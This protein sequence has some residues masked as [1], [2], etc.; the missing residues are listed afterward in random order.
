MTQTLFEQIE[1]ILSELIKIMLPEEY[2]SFIE[3]ETLLTIYD[4]VAGLDNPEGIL[5][6][7]ALKK[8]LNFV[9]AKRDFYN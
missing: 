8:V 5:T 4:K 3:S 7:E 9:K 6:E 2:T 1:D